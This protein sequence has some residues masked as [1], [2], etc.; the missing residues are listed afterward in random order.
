MI[1][2]K[3][4]LNILLP[5]KPFLIPGERFLIFSHTQAFSTIVSDD[6]RSMIN[7]NG[8]SLK[9]VRSKGG[10]KVLANNSQSFNIIQ[11]GRKK[12]RIT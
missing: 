9:L 10:K 12:S 2:Q 6:D 3:N 5:A 1:V 11:G 4:R 8:S 7:R